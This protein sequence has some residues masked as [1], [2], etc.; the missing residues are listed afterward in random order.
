MTD[1]RGKYDDQ[2]YSRSSNPC[3]L[4]K[5]K[6]SEST[7]VCRHGS[8]SDNPH[9]HCCQSL[10]DEFTEPNASEP[11]PFPFPPFLQP[12]LATSCTI[13]HRHATACFASSS[14]HCPTS[15]YSNRLSNPSWVTA[16]RILRRRD[17]HPQCPAVFLKNQHVT[18]FERFRHIPRH[19]LPHSLP[20]PL[21]QSI[22]N[23]FLATHT[24]TNTPP[25]N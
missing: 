22:A 7:S 15:C 24:T 18:S 23:L 6:G 19:H 11:P 25:P 5:P 4:R 20:L 17:L 21:C 16:V 10:S 13:S 9:G 1:L 8:P 12:R 14:Q 2:C 3:K